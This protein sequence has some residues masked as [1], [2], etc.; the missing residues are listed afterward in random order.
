MRGLV[1]KAHRLLHHS[2]LGLRVIKKKAVLGYAPV[3]QALEL[4]LR[5][6]LARRVLPASG[7][8]GCESRL[9]VMA[10]TLHA[11]LTSGGATTHMMLKT[12]PLQMTLA[13]MHPYFTRVGFSCLNWSCAVAAFVEAEVAAVCS[14]S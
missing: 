5:H 6:A 13:S 12:F 2:T 10:Q 1:F 7:E 11:P 14:A 9:I 3:S 4:A 8:L